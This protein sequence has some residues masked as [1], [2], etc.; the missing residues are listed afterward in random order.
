MHRNNLLGCIRTGV[1]L[2][3]AVALMIPGKVWA[4][5]APAAAEQPI[6]T[7]TQPEAA[8]RDQIAKD[9]AERNAMYIGGGAGA[10][11]GVVLLVAG[12]SEANQA[13]D[14]Q[15]CT[16]SGTFTITCD[17]EQHRQQAEDKLDSGR[18]KARIGLGL[19][20][21]GAATLFWSHL[22]SEDVKNLEQQGKQKSF[23]LALEPRDDRSLVLSAQYYF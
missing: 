20:L 3:L 13:H 12:V 4:E 16:Q 2:L 14:V 15:G 10:A 1:S 7:A 5:S 9:K 22:K 21:V 23:H 11:A 19:G 17:S 8:W 6:P 18:Q